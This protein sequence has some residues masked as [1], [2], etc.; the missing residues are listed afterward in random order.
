VVSCCQRPAECEQQEDS[1]AQNLHAIITMGIE[2]GRMVKVF[3][4]KPSPGV[5]DGLAAAEWQY[6][7]QDSTCAPEATDL[8]TVGLDRAD[9]RTCTHSSG[10]V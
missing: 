3:Y 7:R 6:A 8:Q 2:Y 5:D 10:H 1:A 9:I 4:L